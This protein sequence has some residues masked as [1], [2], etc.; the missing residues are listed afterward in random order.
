MNSSLFRG[1]TAVIDDL[2]FGVAAPPWSLPELGNGAVPRTGTARVLVAGL[3]NVFYGDD[4]FGVEVAKRL[5]RR[6][7]PA[8]V[9][10]M[11]FGIRGFDLAYALGSVE[12]VILVDA[13]P[14]GRP[15]GDITV[16]EPN[17]AATGDGDDDEVPD[18]EPHGLEPIGVLRLAQA[19]HRLP[20]RLF[21]VG[22]QP[23]TGAGADGLVGLSAPVRAAVDHAV[24]LCESLAMDLLRA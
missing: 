9:D 5:K 12:S 10:V 11:D 7:L 1:E 3:G 14:H 2:D 22:C 13:Y 21:L 15:P 20:T 18:V 24:S 19:M 16:L 6:Q 8:G 4:G 23:A 17:L